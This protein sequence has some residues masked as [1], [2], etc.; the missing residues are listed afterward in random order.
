M[1]SEF[2]ND[3][4]R[5]G[6]EP[7]LSPRP[8]ER[9]LATGEF[10]WMTGIEDTFITA[11]NRRTG[12]TL[13]E[14]AL[15]GHYDRW[16]SDL[17]LVSELGVRAMRYGVPWHRVNPARNTWDFSWID[18]PLERLLEL[19]VHPIVDLVHYGA[20]AWLDGAF[21]NP[22]YS[23]CVAEYAARVAERYRGRIFSYTPLN[24]PRITAWYCGRLGLWPPY[25]RGAAGFAK[26]MIA[27]CHGIVETERALHDVDPEIVCVPADA[28][29]LYE[30][31][32]PALT[33][34]VE[35]RQSLVFLALDLTM[36]RLGPDDARHARLRELGVTARALDW[37]GENAVTP[38][39]IGLNLYP[40][41]SHKV[42]RRRGGRLRVA[43]PYAGAELLEKLVALYYERYGVPL[44][45]TETASRGSIGRRRAWLSDSVDAV[46][47]ARS[48][49]L[50]IVGYTWWPMF[51][52]VRWGYLAGRLPPAAY[53]EQMGLWDLEPEAG[54]GLRRVPTALVDDYRTLASGGSRSAGPLSKSRSAPPR[55]RSARIN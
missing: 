52:L 9:S 4:P 53:L 3:A 44:L 8:L 25:A 35:L 51:A 11:A 55:T 37:F 7:E 17:D 36:G 34:E 21:T 31:T 47:R 26:V 10:L 2:V 1:R 39:V 41:F 40:M 33:R 32:E 6:V 18:G 43:M 30:T 38:R 16:R 23:R 50:P 45:I 20:P 14:Y 15:T 46:A 29:D 13:D 22:D 54:G 48:R 12:R 19:G 28:T 49:G 24:E 27:I 5:A 42:L